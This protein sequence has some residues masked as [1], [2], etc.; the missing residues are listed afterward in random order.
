[1]YMLTSLINQIEE[2]GRRIVVII[3]DWH[4]INDTTTIEA[5][6][7]LLDHGG[8]LLHLVVTSRTR[9]GL[10]WGRMRVR[11]ELFEIDGAALR[12]DLSGAHAFRV[13]LGGLV[14][15]ERDVAHLEQTTDGWVAGLQLASLSLRDCDNPAA[16][17][18]RMSGRH[19][20]IGEYLA[21]NVLDMLEPQMLDF[22]MAT[23]LTERISGD[24]GGAFAGVGRGQAQR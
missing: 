11:D 16:L 18:S 10:P 23:S 4:R 20:A 1:H 8:Q 14:L 3:D 19:Q 22:L 5:L 7:Y 13:D 24:L 15:D 2:G 21:E 9:A 12:F 6:A 17:I